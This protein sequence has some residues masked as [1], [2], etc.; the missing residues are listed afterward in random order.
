MTPHAHLCKQVS[1]LLTKSGAWWFRPAMTG[2]GRKGI[3][4][5]IACIDG[6]FNA[7]EVKAGRDKLTPWQRRELEA[8]AKAGASVR[9]VRGVQHGTLVVDKD[10]WIGL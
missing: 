10:D 3:P 1:E 2:F 4:D 5:F 7:I 6:H 9:V 8:L